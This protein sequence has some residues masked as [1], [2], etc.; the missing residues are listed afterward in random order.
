[1]GLS[2][3]DKYK[4]NYTPDLNIP[5]GMLAYIWWVIQR[6]PIM[7]VVFIITDILHAIRYPICFYL[8]GQIIDILTG[9]PDGRTILGLVRALVPELVPE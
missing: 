5:C 7:W 8:V 1:M 9:I 6:N 2:K 4:L 3:S